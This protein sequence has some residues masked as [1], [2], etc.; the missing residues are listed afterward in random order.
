[1]NDIEVASKDNVT[2][3]AKYDL[4]LRKFQYTKALDAVMVKMIMKKNPTIT[5]GVMHELIR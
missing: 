5:I 1:M 3:V 4:F 2:R